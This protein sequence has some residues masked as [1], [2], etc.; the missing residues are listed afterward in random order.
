MW[1]PAPSGSDHG[2][3]HVRI[4]VSDQGPTPPHPTDTTGRHG[5]LL[6]RTLISSVGGHLTPLTT[7]HTTYEIVIPIQ[8]PTPP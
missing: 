7:P 8:R 4:R 3:S 5:L 1:K 2:L 6:A